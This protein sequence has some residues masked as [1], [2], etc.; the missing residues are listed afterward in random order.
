MKTLTLRT[1]IAA[2]AAAVLLVTGCS[3]SV[4]AKPADAP[5]PEEL[6][7]QAPVVES[8]S[9]TGE[10]SNE[11]TTIKVPGVEIDVDNGKVSAPGVEVDAK[12]GKVT[13][14]G[15]EVD[16]NGQKVTVDT[17]ADGGETTAAGGSS[18]NEPVVISED[19]AFVRLTGDCPSIT[20][21]GNNVNLGFEKAGTLN[22]TG[23]EGFIRG[24]EAGTVTIEADDNNVGLG[25][26]GDLIVSGSE[27][28][29]RVG[30]RTGELK[31]S[32]KANNIG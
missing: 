21:S 20:V 19:G 18:C 15:V 5:A 16:A 25:Q 3:A 2:A 14:P 31:N 4:D 27:N 28:F 1:G 10:A 12:N 13:A 7:S 32:G 9:P 23:T 24:Q 17:P 29:V 22:I 8:P 30:T 11:G 6:N 26:A